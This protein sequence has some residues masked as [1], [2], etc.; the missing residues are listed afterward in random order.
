MIGNELSFALTGM[1]PGWS[2]HPVRKA[3]FWFAGFLFI[4]KAL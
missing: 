4:F 1:D 2:N 3:G